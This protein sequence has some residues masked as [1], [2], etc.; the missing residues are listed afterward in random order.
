MAYFKHIFTK[1]QPVTY[2]CGPTLRLMQ[3]SNLPFR[4]KHQVPLNPA[5]HSFFSWCHAPFNMLLE[6]DNRVHLIIVVRYFFK[7]MMNPFLFR[8]LHPTHPSSAK[9]LAHWSDAHLITHLFSLEANHLSGAFCSSLLSAFPLT[10]LY[11]GHRSPSKYCCTHCP[12]PED[13]NLSGT[14]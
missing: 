6:T 10:I 9:V 12:D 4:N 3:S 14:Q 2:P 1:V 11:I 13:T 7:Y 5:L 8:L